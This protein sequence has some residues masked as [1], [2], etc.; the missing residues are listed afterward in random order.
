MTATVRRA[1][2]AAGLCL[3]GLAALVVASPTLAERIP[4][5]AA[6]ARLGNDYL[7]VAVVAALALVAV[8]GVLL[9]RTL[10]GVR[11]ATPPTVEG[12]APDAPGRDVD[13]ALDALPPVRVTE[14][15]RRVHE[16]VRAAAV[17]TVAEVHRCSRSAARERV[18]SGEWTDD[19]DAAAF[20]VGEALDPPG[21]GRRV[22]LALRREH[23]FRRRTDATVTALETLE[24][25]SA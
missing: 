17:E 18:E 6:V 12:T 21:V 10:T 24:E 14:R 1:S 15:H 2:A 11:E 7:L 22:V 13:V 25:G 3:F 20:L 8:L 4:T 5:G 9:A 16:R 19:P 23:W